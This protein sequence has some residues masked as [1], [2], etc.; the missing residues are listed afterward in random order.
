MGSVAR[1]LSGLGDTLL[2]LFGGALVVLM[3]WVLLSVEPRR[4]RRRSRRGKH[5]GTG[6]ERTRKRRR[7]RVRQHVARRERGER[8]PPGVYL[9]KG[10]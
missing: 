1:W 7:Q 8:L 2:A 10:P 9:T 4:K 5:P 3:G 6:T